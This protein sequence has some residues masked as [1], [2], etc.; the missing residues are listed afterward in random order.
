MNEYEA[1]FYRSLKDY[2]LD[3]DTINKIMETYQTLKKE[4]A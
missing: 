4:G 1:L 2:G 3:F